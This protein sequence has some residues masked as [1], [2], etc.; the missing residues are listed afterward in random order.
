MIHYC[1]TFCTLIYLSYYTK[2]H[3]K[4]TLFFRIKRNVGCESV[5]K[6]DQVY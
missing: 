2:S 6:E 1:C 3:V 4:L 5:T